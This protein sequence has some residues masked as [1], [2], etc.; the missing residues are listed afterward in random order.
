MAKNDYI[1]SFVKALLLVVKDGSLL[2]DVSEDLKGNS[3]LVL[4]AIK[5]DAIA[6]C[7]ASDRLKNDKRIAMAAVTS[8][9]QALQWLPEKFRD[10]EDIVLAAIKHNEYIVSPLQFASKRLRSDPKIVMKAVADCGN[11]LNC[12]SKEL[13]D[14]KEIMKIA[15]KTAPE[16]WI[17]SEKLQ[18]DPEIRALAQFYENNPAYGLNLNIRKHNQ[19]LFDKEVKRHQTSVLGRL[20]YNMEPELQNNPDVVLAALKEDWRSIQDVP[21]KFRN[22]EP[23]SKWFEMKNIFDKFKSG[24]ISLKDINTEWFSEEQFVF[25]IENVLSDKIYD[26]HLENL[27]NAKSEEEQQKIEE[28]LDREI[29]SNEKLMFFKSAIPIV[30]SKIKATLKLDEVSILNKHRKDIENELNT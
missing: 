11:C 6:Y 25:D 15:L 24:E 18:H 9:S 10:D 28:A 20:L 7:Y 23:F 29:E 19:V 3:W 22:I 16:M 13:R 4:E 27:K 5:Q 8:C 12:V 2:Q 1:N 14:N 30:K 17:V 26:K 21:I